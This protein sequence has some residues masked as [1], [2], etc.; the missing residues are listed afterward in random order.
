MV[1]LSF[2][3]AATIAQAVRW[4]ISFRAHTRKTGAAVASACEK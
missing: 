1:T 2:Q 3:A 4:N